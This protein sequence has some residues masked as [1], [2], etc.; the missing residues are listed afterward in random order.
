M[1]VGIGTEFYLN[2]IFERRIFKFCFELTS[3]LKMILPYLLW[4]NYLIFKRNL[5]SFLL[6]IFSPLIVFIIITIIQK[7]ANEVLEYEELNPPIKR[8]SKIFKCQ[9]EKCVTLAYGVIGRRNEWIDYVIKYVAY[10]NDLNLEKDVKL[11]YE[12]EDYMNYF[13]PFEKYDGRISTGF[14][15]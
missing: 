10:K 9:E 5:S 4:K 8:T 13:D 2:Q 12:G 6:L 11:L 1:K 3:K 14:L 7:M 15:Y